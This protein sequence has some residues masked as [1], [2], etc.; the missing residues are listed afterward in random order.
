MV[1]SSRKAQPFDTLLRQEPES[2][3]PYNE[4]AE[5]QRRYFWLACRLR[6]AT[7]LE[8]EDQEYLVRAFGLL[9]TG[10]DPREVFGGTA[11][12]G[13]RQLGI[14]HARMKRELAIGWI[15][16]SILP[17]NEGGLGMALKDA[18]AKASM[19]FSYS[20]S[21]IRR[22]WYQSQKNVHFVL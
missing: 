9:S 8:P 21:T 16:Q 15:A 12:Q 17:E 4:E 14:Y 3:A 20:L 19:L 1:K 7:G 5:N 10:L 6:A 11:R 22:Y 13:A 2:G 18:L